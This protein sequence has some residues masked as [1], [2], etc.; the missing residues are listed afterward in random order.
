[1]R[2]HYMFRLFLIHLQ[3]CTVGTNKHQCV[4]CD[5]ISGR[6]HIC[7]SKFFCQYIVYN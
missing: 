4:L 7:V 2:T 1:M 5:M 3:V 6:S